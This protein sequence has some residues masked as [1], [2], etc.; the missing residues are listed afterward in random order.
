MFALQSVDT[1]QMVRV[2][3]AARWLKKETRTIRWY[4]ETRKLPAVRSGK[5]WFIAVEAVKA[6]RPRCQ[7]RKKVA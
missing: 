6:F 3:T 7:P 2:A 1:R 5:L 4:I